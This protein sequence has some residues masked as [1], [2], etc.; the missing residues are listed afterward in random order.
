M[1]FRKLVSAL[2]VG[3]AMAATGA[4][5][6]AQIKIG[7]ISSNTGPVALIGIPQKNTVPLL[8]KEIG[9][10]KVEYI[11]Y[12]DASDP[13]VTVKGGKKVITEDKVD[14]ILGPSSLPHGMAT[15]GIG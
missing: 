5:A 1:K 15:P 11:A 8:K 12:D 7:V 13:S 2:T 3:I 6:Q 10:Q 9:G 4:A 14:A